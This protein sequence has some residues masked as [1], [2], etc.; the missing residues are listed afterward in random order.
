M[1]PSF[2]IGSQEVLLKNWHNIWINLNW[3]EKPISFNDHYKAYVL[4]EN[5]TKIY[6]LDENQFE[7]NVGILDKGS[8]HL[9]H[10][11]LNSRVQLNPVTNHYNR[12]LF[13][14]DRILGIPNV[15]TP[16]NPV[17]Q[18]L[19]LKSEFFN[20]SKAFNKFND[21]TEY[22]KD[23]KAGFLKLTLENQGL[24]AQG[25]CFC[26]GQTNDGAGPIT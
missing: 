8:W 2:Y 19:E 7:V 14:D 17:Q 21:S 11:G 1:G 24:P 26:I 12:E 10:N 3:K 20:H 23:T 15:C 25:I 18:V 16:L 9:E 6:G 4:R 13:K 5:G 22:T